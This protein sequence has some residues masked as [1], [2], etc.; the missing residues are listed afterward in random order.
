MPRPPIGGCAAGSGDDAPQRLFERGAVV[1]KIMAQPEGVGGGS[2]RDGAGELVDREHLDRDDLV[3]MRPRRSGQR[4]DIDVDDLVLAQP[5][6]EGDRVSAAE[7][8]REIRRDPDLLEQPPARR[9]HRRLA[10]PRMAATGVRPQAAGMI[11]RRMALLQRDRALP[12]D[13]EN[14]ERPMQEP[15]LVHMKLLAP[16]DAAIAIVGKDKALDLAQGRSPGGSAAPS[17]TYSV[18]DRNAAVRA[19]DALAERGRC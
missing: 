3:R 17:R 11:L 8:E 5:V 10:G 7:G 1:A 2:A 19:Y 14:R 15:G 16:P 12:V 4:T 9:P 6:L 13:E 18:V